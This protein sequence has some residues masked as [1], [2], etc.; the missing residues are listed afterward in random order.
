ME[1]NYRHNEKKKLSRKSL[2]T[3]YKSFARP[4]LD[5]T[6]IIY[7]K[8]FNESF[9][10]KIE[11]VQYKAALMITGAIKGTSRDRLYQELDLE[12]LEDRRWP[13]R[14]FFF[15]KI[16]LGL[17]PSYLHTYHKTVSEG[18][19][20]TRSTTQNKIKPILARIKLFEN[21]FF[22]YCIKEWSK[23]ND[24][25]R[26]IKP[27]NKFKVTILNFIRPKGNS[28]FDIHDTNGIKLLSRLR[29]N[30]SHLN[31]HKFRIT[32]TTR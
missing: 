25:I 7:D 16:I 28:V 24:K 15:H 27:I 29:L 12:S 31:E 2:L 20:L 8:P 19:Y 3:I 5:Y 4:N 11:M 18:V 6:D 30:F 9:K 32:S 13:R 21:L 14:L 10:R 26:N 22:L 23:L 17:L 1:Q